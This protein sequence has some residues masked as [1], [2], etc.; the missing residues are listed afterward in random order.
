MDLTTIRHLRAEAAQE[1]E[2]ALRLVCAVAMRAGAILEVA[3]LHASQRE[4]E[5]LAKIETEL[6]ANG[7]AE[8]HCDAPRV[9]RPLP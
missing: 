7:R 5:V 9:R 8:T 6:L 2:A 1:A 3:H 4:L